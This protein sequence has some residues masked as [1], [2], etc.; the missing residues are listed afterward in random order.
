M[1]VITTQIE[2]SEQHSELRVLRLN[3]RRGWFALDFEEL[4]AYREYLY[5]FVWRDI[6]VRYKQTV[7]D[8]AWA[9]LQPL[10]TML[11]FTL[12]FGRLAKIPSI[13]LVES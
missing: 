2:V 5:F 3:G 8:S 13:G 1:G 10:M 11:V 7:I 4:W 6:K 12:F 9:I